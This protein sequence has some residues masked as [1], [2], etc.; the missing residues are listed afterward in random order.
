MV[1]DLE[2]DFLKCL[3]I[4]IVPVSCHHFIGADIGVIIIVCF[5]IVCE[6]LGIEFAVI[7]KEAG[8]PHSLIFRGEQSGHVADVD[9]Q[10]LFLVMMCVLIKTLAGKG[11]SMIFPYSEATLYWSPFHFSDG[12]FD[13]LINIVILVF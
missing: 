8:L 4:P 9:V 10:I 13:K 7:M 6:L 3:I 5:P 12:W 1:I 11:I 2:K